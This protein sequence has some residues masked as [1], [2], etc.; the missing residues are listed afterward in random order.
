MAK[1]FFHRDKPV[2]NVGT[3][4]HIDHGKT[5][6]TSA[7]LAVQSQDGLAEFKSYDEV[8]KGGIVRDK[9]KT[10]TV[11]TSHVRYESAYRMYAHVDC[12]GH[13]DYVKNMISG[14]SQMDG[15]ILLVSAIDGVMPQTREHV[16]LARQVGVK[17]LVVFVNKCDLVSD[18]ELLEL[19]E[20]DLRELL[21]HFGFDGDGIPFVFG[22]AQNAMN[23]PGDPEAAACIVELLANLDASIPDPDR[24][25]DKPF[26]M[27]VENVLNIEG[28]GTVVT[29]HIEQGQIRA[30]E[31]VDI[32]GIR[33]ETKS[34]VCTQVETFQ[35][36]LEVGQA[37][38]SVGCLLRGI[39]REDVDRGQVL[40]APGTVQSKTEFLAEVYVL[41]K[42]EGGRHTPFFDGY[43]PQFFFRSTHV[44]GRT[45]I[46]EQDMAMPGDGV[47]LKVRLDK[48]IA[49]V[50][51][52]RFA[53]REG[54]RTIGS[55]VVTEIGG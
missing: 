1:T 24:P 21:T 32:V 10:V 20:M 2:V 43:Q 18:P 46:V 51:G 9:N 25:L 52:A 29:G 12:P 16:L 6:L 11:I 4:G 36:I 22:S 40:V 53:I 37:G 13:A 33:D 34:V 44:A 55:G 38:D 8:A 26:Y 31:T 50:E 14:A 47:Q 48:P 17:D 19:I 3:I 42:E 35:E 45:E 27:P 39:S 41:A 5:T 30:G 15:A 54:R 7:I 23:D 49:L 28:R